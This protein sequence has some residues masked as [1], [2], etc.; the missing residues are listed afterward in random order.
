MKYRVSDVV[1]CND[2]EAENAFEAAKL[3]VKEGEW[4]ELDHTIW[5]DVNVTPL[6]DKGNSIEDESIDETIALH[7]RTPECFSEDGRHQ[8]LSPIELVGGVTENPGCF[9]HGGGAIIIEVCPHCGC[10]VT[11]D[12]WAQ[13]PDTGEQGLKSYKYDFNYK[14]EVLAFYNKKEKY[15][16]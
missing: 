14:D 10:R 2:Y 12:T 3:F 7:P 15:N 13:R 8:W 11:F 16:D 1:C 4:G 9:G 5:I 6:D